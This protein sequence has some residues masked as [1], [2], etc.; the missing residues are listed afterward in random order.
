MTQTIFSQKR[1][2]DVFT[3]NGQPLIYVRTLSGNSM[4]LIEKKRTPGT[5]KV[6]S[7]RRL[8]EKKSYPGGRARHG[9]GLDFNPRTLP[10]TNE[11]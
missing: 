9:P 2:P 11:T 10:H 4:S 1:I 5:L 3:L 6:S 8:Y 7:R